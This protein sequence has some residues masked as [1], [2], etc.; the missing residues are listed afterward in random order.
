LY[1][2]LPL[3]TAT[4][5]DHAAILDLIAAAAEVTPVPERFV[6]QAD[7][8]RDQEQVMQITQE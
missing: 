5:S 6:W 2:Y 1:S 7:S 8:H 3:H 4:D